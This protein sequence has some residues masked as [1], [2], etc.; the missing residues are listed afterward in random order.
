LIRGEVYWVDF[1]PARGG[2]IRKQRPAII[3]SNDVSNRLLNRM[4][5]VPLTSV[6]RRVY[7]SD[8]LIKLNGVP[9]KA[10][11]NQ[12]RTVAKERLHGRI[13]MLGRYDLFAVE[14][15]IRVQLGLR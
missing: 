12:I 13:E 8:A 6:T 7:P 10:M 2:E 1:E 11:A 3:V 4:Q 9:H 5:V 15:A 14:D